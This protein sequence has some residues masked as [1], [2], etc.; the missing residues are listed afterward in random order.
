M[1]TYYVTVSEFKRT[2]GQSN[3]SFRDDLAGRLNS[4]KLADAQSEAKEY[5]LKLNENLDEA[6]RMKQGLPIYNIYVQTEREAMASFS[7]KGYKNRSIY[8]IKDSDTQKKLLVE[9]LSNFDFAC[10]SV[11]ELEQ[12]IA[13]VEK[14]T[15]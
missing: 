6:A 1:K 5:C 14:E 8:E 3:M 10:L 11:A 2:D 13:I 4:T 7:F 15:K 9:R 12:I